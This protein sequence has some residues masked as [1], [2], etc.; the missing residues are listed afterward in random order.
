MKYVSWLILICVIVGS[1]FVARTALK[2]AMRMLLLCL[3]LCFTVVVGY[4][5]YRSLK[6]K[7]GS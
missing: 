6:S 5:V 2:V 1:F 3:P 4:L 7:G